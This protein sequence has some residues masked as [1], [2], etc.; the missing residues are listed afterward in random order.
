MRRP[1]SPGFTPKERGRRVSGLEGLWWG[2]GEPWGTGRGDTWQ[3]DK[4]H[5]LS[6][7]LPPEFYTHPTLPFPKSCPSVFEP[8]SRAAKLAGWGRGSRLSLKL[9]QDHV[10]HLSCPMLGLCLWAWLPHLSQGDDPAGKALGMVV[11]SREERFEEI[12]RFSSHS[13]KHKVTVSPRTRYFAFSPEE[14]VSIFLS[15]Q[16]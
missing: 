9:N 4:L 11:S 14:C 1:G 6:Y 16:R 10:T 13:G 3:E 5:H 15:L 12:G 8:H 7:H 2:S